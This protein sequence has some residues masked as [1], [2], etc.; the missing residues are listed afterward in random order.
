MPRVPKRR[1][2]TEGEIPDAVEDIL[3]SNF[4][5]YD[6]DT[7]TN[8][9]R[10]HDDHDG[11]QRGSLSV[12]F[13]EDGDAWVSVEGVPSGQSL[14]YRMASGGGISFR[15]RVALLI[16]AKAIKLDNENPIR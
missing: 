13:S 12:M 8:Y 16:L 7:R 5:L 9:H 1:R 3:E 10:L 2:I 11:T 14:R 4:W 15:T 6:I